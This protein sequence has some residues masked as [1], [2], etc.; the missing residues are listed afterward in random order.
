[1]LR[2]TLSKALPLR[3]KVSLYNLYTQ[4]F[5]LI[6]GKTLGLVG[7]NV[8]RRSDFYSPLPT[9][10]ALKKN[11][12]RWNRPS[13]LH[14]KSFDVEEMKSLISGLLDSY[15]DEFMR[16]PPYRDLHS[17][18]FGLGY[19]PID[20]LTLYLMIRSLKPGNYVEV[21]SGLST[22]YCHL[23]ADRNRAEGFPLNITC[24]EPFPSAKLYSIPGVEVIDSE[25]QDVDISFFQRLGSND[26]L[27][28]DSSHV[29]RIDSDV[30]Y[31]YLEILPSINKGTYIHIHDISL[32]YN[33]PYPPQRWIFETTP[34]M[35]WNEAM[36]LQAFLA[37]N[38]EFKVVLSTPLIRHFDEGFLQKNIPIYETIDEN[39]NAFSSLWLQ[40]TGR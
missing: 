19:T 18:G 39:S 3:V 16:I 11:I 34:P 31:L 9:T 2:K 36:V 40:R 15:L 32:P 28:I 23:A 30:P 22:Y 6:L 1:M 38:D 13:A 20:A 33:I 37:F 25:V 4:S 21:G 27:F 10:S 35:F 12:D 8:S 29:L 14:G 24:I 26:V 17:L 7:Y 5:P